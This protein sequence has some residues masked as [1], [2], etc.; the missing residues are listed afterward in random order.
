VS[1]QLR[2]RAFR[3]FSW[4]WSGWE[5]LYL[6]LQPVTPIREGSL[7][8]YRRSGSVLHLHLDGRALGRMRKAAG[9]STF[10]TVHQLREELAVLAARVR[11]GE[12]GWVKEIRGRSLIGGAG[13]VF[14]FQTAPVPR[15]IGSALQ[16]YYFVGLD[17]IHNPLGLRPH[18]IRRWPVESTMTV[19][20][21]LERYPEKSAR[22]SDAR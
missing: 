6:R 9:Y 5:R 8:A 2:W 3:A 17:A 21:L 4:V 19:E 10:H 18:S 14:G 7:F 1:T 22:S 11:S 12:L 13:G 16:Q 20:A 15:T